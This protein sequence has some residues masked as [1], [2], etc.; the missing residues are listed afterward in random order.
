MMGPNIHVCFIGVIWKIIPKESVL[1]S[2]VPIVAKH[3]RLI[4]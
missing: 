1:P 3:R 4:V 2:V